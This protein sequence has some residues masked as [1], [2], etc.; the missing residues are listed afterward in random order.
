VQA[1]DGVNFAVAKGQVHALMGENGAGKS[2]LMKIIAGLQSPDGGEISLRDRRVQFRNPHEALCAGICMIHQELMPFRNLTVAENIFI[3][4]EP[5]RGLSGWLDK[6]AMHREAKRLLERLGIAL[7]PAQSM[8]S[9]SVAE[10]QTV[11]IAKA[12]AHKAS[13]LIMDE[14]TSAISDREVE[15]L[16]AVIRDLQREGVAVIYISHKMDEVL[17]IADV[18]TVLRDGRHVATHATSELNAEKLIALMVGRELNKMPGRRGAVRNMGDVALEVRNLT[19]AGKFRAVSF[20]LRQGEIMGVAGLMG[21]GRTDL[22]NAI[23]GLAPADGGEIRVHGRPA[24]I[25]NPRD[26]IAC[27]I[28]LVG[29]DRKETGLVPRMSV[30]HNI[31]LASLRRCC[32]GAV[33]DYRAE[34]RIA[35]E[36]IRAFAI[37]TPDRNRQVAYLSG[38]NQQK[39]VIAKALLTG[40]SILMLDDPTRGIDIGAKTEVYALITKLAA[41]GQAVLLVSSELPELLALSDRLLVMCA[42]EVTAELDPGQTT[43]AEVLKHAMPK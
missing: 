12:L 3:G 23:F 31:T 39:V 7:S 41:A 21:A 2:T 22:V 15:A 26:A 13:V 40:P 27:G 14:P 34:N 32:R 33:I 10:L 36:Q 8:Q 17:R 43:Q 20:T 25:R 38:G 18:V 35:D 29:E 9:L 11:E 30:K 37:K 1:L 19:K 4:Q 24:R 28:A 16:F 42:G 5:V 6:P